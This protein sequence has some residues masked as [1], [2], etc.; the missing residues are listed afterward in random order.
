MIKNP[1]RVL[2]ILPSF[3]SGG[4]E[5]YV[6]DIA[7]NMPSDEGI[8][9]FV[10]SSGGQLEANLPLGRH[11]SL[12][13]NTKNP[14]R[15]VMNIYRLSR[16]I[17]NFNI[18][19]LNA[20]SR[21]PAW[22]ALAASRLMK[23][24]FITT[25]HG[26]YKS[27]GYFKH[28][29]NSVM[30]RG[31]KI[32]AIS[33]YIEEHINAHYPQKASQ[34]KPIYEGIN[35]YQFSKACVSKDEV[36]NFRKS[37]NLVDG[38]ILVTLVGRLTPI[39]GHITLLEAVK[40][41][42]NPKVVILFLGSAG[43]KISFEAELKILA[44]QSPVKTIFEE[45]HKPLEQVYAASD[46]VVSCSTK[47][48]AFGRVMAEAIAM[49]RPLIATNHGG[50]IELTENGKWGV[51]V[52]P[53]DPVALA[54]ALAEL[55]KSPRKIP[56]GGFVF[57]ERHYSLQGMLSKLAGLYRSVAIKNQDNHH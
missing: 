42:N 55:T 48:E 34:I 35:T 13:L 30:A 22:S 21:A 57:I 9:H 12:P 51:L 10:A 45:N 41:L 4:V 14:L 38:E 40:I 32:V 31:H 17:K 6:L 25:F 18:H 36:K 49:E 28:L 47:P 54:Q 50:A 2:H 5:S 33:N 26:A 44:T 23:K 39:K 46:I 20:H 19:V 29:Y 56:K 15:M 24:P 11:I 27:G 8:L 1:I 37:L 3:K 16:A 52:P 43:T 7:L 53:Q